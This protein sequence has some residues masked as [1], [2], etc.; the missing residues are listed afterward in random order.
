MPLGLASGMAFPG[1]VS[2]KKNGYSSFNG[3]AEIAWPKRKKV[4]WKDIQR[5]SYSYLFLLLLYGCFVKSNFYQKLNLSFFIF[6]LYV[7]PYSFITVH[8][9]RLSFFLNVMEREEM[10]KWNHFIHN[11]FWFRIWLNHLVQ[12]SECFFFFLY[13]LTLVW[14]NPWFAKFV[15]TWH[16]K[17]HLFDEVMIV[18]NIVIH[19][20]EP[21]C[22][23]HCLLY[24]WAICN[25][26]LAK[27]DGK[28]C[29]VAQ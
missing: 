28:R 16:W 17:W 10:V 5:L 12:G 20:F 15:C 19:F 26:R 4:C 27:I 2:C 13:F 29:R 7:Q 24:Q 11:L 1:V 21:Q 9:L 14:R 6:F 8:F 22:W 18:R 25:R 3:D 23:S